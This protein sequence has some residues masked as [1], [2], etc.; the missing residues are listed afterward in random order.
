MKKF[1]AAIL[2]LAALCGLLFLGIMPSS[3]KPGECGNFHPHTEQFGNDGQVVLQ[4]ISRLIDGSAQFNAW[5]QAGR[6]VLQFRFNGQ[7]VFLAYGTGN[8]TMFIPSRGTDYIREQTDG[9]KKVTS[10]D[11]LNAVKSH[12]G[13]L[14]DAYSQKL[15]VP[16]SQP[17][18]IPAAKDDAKLLVLGLAG[19]AVMILILGVCAGRMPRTA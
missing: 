14:R 6:T 17:V 13:C 7:N 5:T 9:M 8:P 12:L 10:V 1:L 18:S 3:P 16:A 2:V 11:G 19:A 15:T 4:I